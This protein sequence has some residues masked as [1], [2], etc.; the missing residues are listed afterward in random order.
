MVDYDNMLQRTIFGSGGLN[1]GRRP[2]MT[3]QSYTLAAHITGVP[4][5][6]DAAEGSEAAADINVVVAGDIDMLYSIFFVLRERGSDQDEELDLRFDNVTF[7]LNALDFLAGDDRFIEIRKRRPVHRT[8]ARVEA[9][10]QGI[11][12]QAN[13]QAERYR[14]EFDRRQAE[15]RQRFDQAIETLQQRQGIDLKQMVMEVQAAMQA[16][17]RQMEATLERLERERDQEIQKTERSLALEI[18]TIQD[19]FKF[20][21]VLIPPIL[22]IVLAIVIYAWRRRL[23][24]IGVPER[25]L[26]RLT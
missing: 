20:A 16:N 4:R 23:E 21:A 18:R 2:R 15:H 13:S 9:R 10:T 17:E 24:K 11:T 8:L 5:A 1:P 22:P 19:R 26:G 6:A 7:V 3:R 12:D 25:R 14:D